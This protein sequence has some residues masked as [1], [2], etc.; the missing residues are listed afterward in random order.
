MHNC[1]LRTKPGNC[2][3][4][5]VLILQYS[6]NIAQNSLRL[7]EFQKGKICICI[8]SG[9]NV[10]ALIYARLHAVLPLRLQLLI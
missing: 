2:K 7:V 3:V 10:G 6:V 8:E 1:A 4:F 5:C 9:K